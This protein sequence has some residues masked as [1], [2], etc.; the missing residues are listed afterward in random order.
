MQFIFAII[1]SFSF[2]LEFQFDSGED[3]VVEVNGQELTNPFMGGFNRPQI[4][5]LD[6]DDDTDSD[7]FAMDE[8]GRIRHFEN[9]TTDGEYRFQLNSCVYADLQ[10]GGWFFFDDFDN[11]NFI[12]LIIQDPTDLNHARFLKKSGDGYTDMG[13]LLNPLMDL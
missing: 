6:A 2:A 1:I 7:L 3:I 5:W 4:Q 8:D 9:I 11:D 12:D 10:T 13:K